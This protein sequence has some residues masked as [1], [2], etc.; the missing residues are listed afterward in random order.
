M[1]S[2]SIALPSGP[3]DGDWQET[4]L[5]PWINSIAD[6]YN[7]HAADSGIHGG[8]GGSLAQNDLT[9]TVI[10]SPVQGQVISYTG[11]TF[12]N[13]YVGPTTRRLDTD[14]GLASGDSGATKYTKIQAAL[15]DVDNWSIL[16]VPIGEWQ[17]TNASAPLSWPQRDNKT[18]MGH[19]RGA[20][21]IMRTNT[22]DVPAFQQTN[23][24]ATAGT[25]LNTV[26][27]DLDLGYV[28]QPSAA[29]TQA[30]CLMV[31]QTTSTPSGVGGYASCTWQNLGFH[32]GSR[33]FA[34]GGAGTSGFAIPIFQSNFNDF[35]FKSITRCFFDFESPTAVGTTNN[36]GEGWHC[37]NNGD[38]IS[39]A[40]YALRF[41]GGAEFV[42]RDIDLE[43]NHDN[44]SGRGRLL[45]VVG[46]GRIT[47]DR[48][49]WE[50]WS[51]PSGDNGGDLIFVGDANL[52]IQQV[53]W[54]I[55]SPVNAGGLV[56]VFNVSNVG[57]LWIGDMELLHTVTSGS[58]NLLDGDATGP[59][60]YVWNYTTAGNTVTLT[61]SAVL[62]RVRAF[63]GTTYVKSKAGTPTDSDVTLAADGAI[64]L[65]TSTGKFTG[66]A[67][68]AWTALH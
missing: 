20:S 49:R 34:I 24:V 58:I 2:D 1:V 35:Y 5:N 19:G 21:R 33:G 8:G 22:D 16:V 62:P 39:I 37:D 57:H 15:D 43:G 4:I 36:R 38:A 53:R 42:L 27:K 25:V 30:A 56:K 52:T 17:Y 23:V 7:A 55:N 60:I 26:L 61:S 29:H 13:V 64:M 63:D 48:I 31:S 51:I 32:K 40:D 65:N 9:D 50:N 67:A 44:A 10:A 45:Y 18:L 3:S 47:L 68:G 28:T 14:Y 54:A 41:V 11:S 66:R 6:A 12:A 59:D 46:G